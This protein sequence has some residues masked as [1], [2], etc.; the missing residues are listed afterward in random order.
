MSKSFYSKILD[1]IED[2]RRK[3]VSIHSSLE[4]RAETTLDSEE[5]RDL[6]AIMSIL[7]AMHNSL[8]EMYVQLEG[9]RKRCEKHE[10]RT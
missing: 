5:Q 6:Y 3:I 8:R 2:A 10:Q 9:L 1:D 7:S 4:L